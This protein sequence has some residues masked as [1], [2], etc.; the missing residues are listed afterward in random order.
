MEQ[1]RNAYEHEGRSQHKELVVDGRW[2]DVDMTHLA[3]DMD[4]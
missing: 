3:Q 2:K 4:Q 1:I